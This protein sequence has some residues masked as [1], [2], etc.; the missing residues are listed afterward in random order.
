MKRFGACAISIFMAFSLA[1][2]GSSTPETGVVDGAFNCT[3]QEFIDGLN[4]TVEQANNDVIYSIRD[5]PGNGKEL[6]ID[7]T[8][9]TLTLSENSD[10]KLTKVY[11]Y[12]YSG[13][14]NENVITSAGCYC[15][16]ILSHLASADAD[17]IS[18]SISKIV[19]SGSGSTERT[20]K[21]GNVKVTF[22]ATDTGANRL[23]VSVNT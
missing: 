23:N 6:Q 5:Y 12:W 21:A 18:S 8:S 4:T 1:A 20:T 3:P 10:G 11:L 7:S 19:S 13:D 15:G 17:D 14:N 2:C 16:Y 22:E 9:L